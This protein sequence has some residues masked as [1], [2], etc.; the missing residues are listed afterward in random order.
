MSKLKDLPVP[1]NG[2]LCS[3]DVVSLFRYV[4]LVENTDICPEA[5]YRDS[6]IG[7]P[8][9]VVSNVENDYRPSSLLLSF[10]SS[11]LHEDEP[12]FFSHTLSQ[13]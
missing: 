6:D 13:V 1:S 4:P 3:F 11:S 10:I 2:Y 5:L 7:S 8:S 9:M 12:G